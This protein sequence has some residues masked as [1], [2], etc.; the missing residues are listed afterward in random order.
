[1]STVIDG[2]LCMNTVITQIKKIMQGSKYNN[3]WENSRRKQCNQ[4]MVISGKITINELLTLYAPDPI[5]A[6]YNPD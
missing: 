6:M 1:M 4:Y 3:N 5:P 2:F